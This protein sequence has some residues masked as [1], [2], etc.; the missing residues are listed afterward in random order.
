MIATT[1][2]KRAFLFFLGVLALLVVACGADSG[3]EGSGILDAHPVQPTLRP[4]TAD[5]TATPAPAVLQATP[6][7]V[8][9][10]TPVATEDDLFLQM[11]APMETEILTSEPS[12]D[13]IGRTRVDAVVTINDTVV[14]PGLDG[15]FSLG[16]DLEEGPNI[17]EVVASMASGEQEDVV[18]VVI[19]V[20]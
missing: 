17:I 15:R 7:T 6:T 4:E 9:A 18:L 12:L 11:V 13:I 20:S 3:Q 1:N 19:Y 5:P 16:I 8:P 10:A 14:K 2:R